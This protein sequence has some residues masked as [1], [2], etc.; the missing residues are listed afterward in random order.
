M[1]NYLQSITEKKALKDAGQVGR[2]KANMA[3]AQKSYRELEL[4]IKK[5]DAFS[6]YCTPMIDSKI[7]IKSHINNLNMLL[8]ESNYAHYSVIRNYE[9]SDFDYEELDGYLCLFGDKFTFECLSDSSPDAIECEVRYGDDAWNMSRPD[10]LEIFKSNRD[11]V[12]LDWL[13]GVEK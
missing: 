7:V 5:I 13:Q 11:A 8:N 6:P 9:I 2:W 10:I 3:S 4:A 12:V 1:T